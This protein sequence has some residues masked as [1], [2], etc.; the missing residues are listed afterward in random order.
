[1]CGRGRKGILSFCMSRDALTSSHP[2][3]PYRPCRPFL[4]SRTQLLLL[5]LAAWE[6]W[7]AWAVW[8]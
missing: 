3:L 7:A 4:R 1:M 6:E 5:W 2:C 8:E